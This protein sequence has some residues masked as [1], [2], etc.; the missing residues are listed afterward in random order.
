MRPMLA[1]PGVT[2]LDVDETRNRVVVGV[3]PGLSASEREELARRIAAS[4]V[5]ATAVSIEVQPPVTAMVSLQDRFRPVVGGLQILFPID[6]PLYG[7]C[8]LGFNATRGKTKGFVTNSHCTGVEGEPDGVTYSQSL[9][10]HGDIGREV[11]DPALFT[12]APCPDGRRCR[13]SDSAF[14]KYDNPKTSGLGRLARPTRQTTDPPTLTVNPPTARFN[15]VGRL[16]SPLA[17]TIVHKVG[18]TTGW[19]AGSILQTCV[20]VNVSGTD[21]TLLCQSLVAA[22]V[23]SGDS[24]SPV[25]TRIGSG[26]NAKLVGI[27]W[28][29]GS[30]GASGFR[31][32]VFSPLANIERE[33]GAL[34][35]N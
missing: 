9:P 33:L 29:G 1:L 24:G 14:A 15:V 20:D 30:A 17:G 19:S 25:F 10:S 34:K 2:M 22:D 21:I 28:G 31:V 27:L 5:P 18:R 13:F 11:A 23:D 35:V 12:G 7:V 4:D 6:P 8:T 16:A 26:A 32:F 3:E